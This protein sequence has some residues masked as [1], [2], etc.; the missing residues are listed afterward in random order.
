MIFKGTEIL[1]AVGSGEVPGFWEILSKIWHKY[2][3]LNNLAN[4][5]CENQLMRH[6]QVHI[7]NEVYNVCVVIKK[8]VQWFVFV[9]EFN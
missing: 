3:H 8:E 6:C 9:P 2:Q 5:F 4:M 7:P 1:S